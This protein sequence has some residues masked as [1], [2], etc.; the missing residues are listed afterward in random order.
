MRT[1]K[2]VFMFSSDALPLKCQ[3]ITCR[4]GTICTGE[5]AR[6]LFAAI[7]TET[8]F[9]KIINVSSDLTMTLPC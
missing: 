1:L 9:K 6:T 3:K 7:F 2:N 4:P 5:L 8:P